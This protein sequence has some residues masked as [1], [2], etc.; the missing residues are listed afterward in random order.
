[1]HKKITLT[2][3]GLKC[4]SRWKTVFVVA[5]TILVFTI[6]STLSINQYWYGTSD[7]SI[8]IPFLKAFINNNL[9]PNDYLLTQRP[10]YYTYLWNVLG[11]LVKYLNI[12]IP[13]L[14]FLSYFT[15]IYMTFLGVYL[16][17]ITLFKKK[18]VAFLS[19]FFLLFSKRALAGAIT[20]DSI[21]ITRVAALPILL[22][23]IY[24]FFKKK[25]LLSFLLQ[26]IGFLVHPMTTVYVIAIIFVSS[27]VNLRDIGIRRF[28]LCITVLI[29]SSSPILIWKVLHSPVSLNLLYANP[30]WIE[31]LRLRSP[32]HIFP[33]SWEKDVFFKTVLLLCVF[34]ISWKHRPKPD[35]H[36]IVVTFTATIFTMC[37]AG[38]IFSEFV[39]LSIVLNFQFLR[40]SQFVVFFAMIYFSN[41]FFAEIQFRESIFNKLV[42]A[43]VSI[44]IFYGATGWKYAYVVFLAL[45]VFLIFYHFVYRREF[46]LSKY[47]VLSLVVIV[48]VLGSGAYLKKGNFLI[49]NAQEGKWLDV[50]I[51]AKQNTS[52]KDMYIVPPTIEGFRVESERTI[53]GD[54]KDGTLMNFNPNF[55]YEWFRRMKKLGYREGTAFKEGFKNLTETDFVNIANEETRNGHRTFLVMFKERDT[56]NFSIV[57]KNEKFIVYEVAQ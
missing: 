38:I 12:S 34:F 3:D 46:L 53:Y 19:L 8:T 21:F 43:F 31:L 42:V 39:P 35:Y 10:Y 41:Y 25:Y 56:L 55:G 22:F 44:G 51:W 54:W 26:G 28:L 11:F 40:S 13:A 4:D 20:L 14:F 9:Y 6:V 16:I 57:Y 15:A 17:T 27:I 47:F 5:L 50:Q 7:Q 37:A 1:M 33:F 24:L 2:M 52:P 32:G 48:L 30:K 23:S 49:D 45:S 29:I 36:R 18:G